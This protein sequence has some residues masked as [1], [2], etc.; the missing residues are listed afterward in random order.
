MIPIS[1]NHYKTKMRKW[2]LCVLRMVV[3]VYG[4]VQ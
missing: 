1:Q 3:L 4:N 2:L